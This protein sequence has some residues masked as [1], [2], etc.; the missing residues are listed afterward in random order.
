MIPSPGRE[1]FW[2]KDQ[3]CKT[4]IHKSILCYST[5]VFIL[6]GFSDWVRFFLWLGLYFEFIS[7]FFCKVPIYN[8]FGG[9]TSIRKSRVSTSLWKVVCG[10]LAWMPPSKS[11]F[12]GGSSSIF[13]FSVLFDFF[14]IN[15]K[16]I[17]KNKV[18]QGNIFF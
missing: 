3:Q 8:F 4:Y 16:I 18:F 9:F 15:L 7:I 12:L 13:G 2:S 10:F 14:G 17:A 5:K 6:R 1:H 11:R